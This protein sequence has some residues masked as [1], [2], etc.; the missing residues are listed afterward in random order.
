MTSTHPNNPQD[1]TQTSLRVHALQL[2]LL[3]NTQQKAEAVRALPANGLEVDSAQRLV[4]PAGVP[5]RPE[6]PTLVQP[7]ALKHRSVGTTQ[8]H[9]SLIHALTH[10]E[11]NAINLALDAVWRFADMPQ[12]YY[13]DWWQVAVEEALHFQLL[14]DHLHTLGHAYGDFPAHDGLWDMAFRTQADLLARLALVPRT[15]EARGLD[16]TP[17]IRTK[18]ISIGDK[19]GAAI[20]DI[21]LRDEIGHVATGNRWYAAVCSQRGLDPVSTYAELARKHSAPVLKGPFNLAA[22]RAAGFTD[23]ELAALCGTP[24]IA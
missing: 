14:Q 24:A 12:A 17:A 19:S 3:G 9:A 20:L 16:A 11:A 10:I 4:E 2:L 8:G 15:L 13:R 5:G 18:L 23:T 7:A 1:A 22:R 21:I 6:R